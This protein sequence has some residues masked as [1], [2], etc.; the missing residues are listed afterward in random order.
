M[1]FYLIGKVRFLGSKAMEEL[2]KIKQL[3]PIVLVTE[4]SISQFSPII[5]LSNTIAD[6]GLGNPFFPVKTVA[7][8]TMPHSRKCYAVLMEQIGLNSLPKSIKKS[9]PSRMKMGDGRMTL[10][11]KQEK[12]LL[13]AKGGGGQ[14]MGNKGRYMQHNQY[15]PI[16]NTR[17]VTMAP[18]HINFS[19]CWQKSDEDAWRW[20]YT[21]GGWRRNR[22][23]GK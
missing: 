8:D 9:A 21:K 19:R 11:K 17:C 14:W 15:N 4:I 12:K 1:S 6:R 10:S 20:N 2:R 22:G 23:T 3:K 5:L 13:F 18:T 16:T 7:V